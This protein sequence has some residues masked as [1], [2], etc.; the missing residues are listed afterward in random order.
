[1]PES[2]ERKVSC[3]DFISLSITSGSVV[4]V[5]SVPESCEISSGEE[6]SLE[7]FGFDCMSLLVTSGSV[8]CMS[9]CPASVILDPTALP[10]HP[11]NTAIILTITNLDT[12]PHVLFEDALS[13][14]LVRGTFVV[15]D[16]SINFYRVNV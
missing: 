4:S 6:A 2:G 10:P 5:V 16:F 7:L 11:A 1:M 8:I 12:T 13:L 3:F 15:G 9:V 14:V